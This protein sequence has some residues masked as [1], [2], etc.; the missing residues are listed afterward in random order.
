ML[1]SL[2]PGHPVDPRV[3][4]LRPY[5]R[6]FVAGWVLVVVPLLT[7]A[8]GWTLWNLPEFIARARGGIQLQQLVFDVAW[9][10]RDWPAMALAVISI[11]LL[12]V[13]LVGIAVVLW[14]LAASLTTF[15]RS[16][17]AAA[18]Q[19]LGGADGSRGRGPRPRCGRPSTGAVGRGLHRRDHVRTTG[20][21]AGTRMAPRRLR[22]QRPPAQSGAERS[23]AAPARARAAPAHAHQGLAPGRGHEPQGRRRQDD[24]L[25][26]ARQHVRH[27]SGATGSSPSTPIPTRA[28]SPTGSHHRTTAPSPTC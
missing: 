24:D 19:G 12:L 17:M 4:E 26:G 2:R 14:R 27:C 6:R 11:A 25:P 9:Q 7:A 15:V 23:G 1:R 10:R 21:R 22:R 18:G 20:A 28:T 5:A 13:P 16:R 3:T 8:L